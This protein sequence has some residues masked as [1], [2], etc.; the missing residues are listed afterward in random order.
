L[1]RH[2]ENIRATIAS[3]IGGELEGRTHLV[4]AGLLVA[5]MIPG[6]KSPLYTPKSHF[7]FSMMRI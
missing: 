6:S 1:L 7:C 4:G 2:D 5:M 3:N